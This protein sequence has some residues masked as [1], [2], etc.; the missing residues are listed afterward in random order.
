MT[1][2]I[3]INILNEIINYIKYLDI[4]KNLNKEETNKI[5]NL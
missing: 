4:K 1:G 5:K 2:K 3:E